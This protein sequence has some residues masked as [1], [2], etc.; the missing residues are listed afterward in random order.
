[1][2]QDV[3]FAFVHNAI[4][5][6]FIETYLFKDFVERARRHLE[7]ATKSNVSQLW[8]S[9]FKSLFKKLGEIADQVNLNLKSHHEKNGSD[10][11]LA[12][13]PLTAGLPEV[14]HSG[15]E[16]R[17]A[18]MLFEHVVGSNSMKQQTGKVL[19]N[20][21]SSVE[22]GVVRGETPDIHDVRGEE[23][24]KM[25]RVVCSCLFKDDWD[26]LGPLVTCCQSLP[27][28]LLINDISSP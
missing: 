11:K 28:Q 2:Q 12:E 8:S 13:N 18:H 5:T 20:W 4:A 10:Q 14:S 26:T 6:R 16:V 3:H 27:A 17:S 9:C 21:S 22:M 15:W 23:N 25:V 24:Q 19:S 7:G 1:M